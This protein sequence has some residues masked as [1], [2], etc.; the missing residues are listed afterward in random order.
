MKV[1]CRLNGGGMAISPAHSQALIHAL[2]MAAQVA[3]QKLTAENNRQQMQ[4][5]VA[6]FETK[7]DIMRDL[8]GAL[9]ERR[10]EAVKSGFSEVLALYADQA[11]GYLEEK[12]K[13]TEA[14]IA[15]TDAMQS[16]RWRKRLGEVD[17]E[18]RE[19]RADAARLY[20][21]MTEIVLKLGGDALTLSPDYYAALSLSSPRM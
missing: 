16:A 13:I 4:M 1:V 18:L 8:L 9:V 14:E 6:M 7:A 2:S 17:I 20:N 12:R 10:V 19:I 3:G 5:A 11:R 15:T 21:Q